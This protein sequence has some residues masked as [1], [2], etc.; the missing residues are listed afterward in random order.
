MKS[1][2]IL[3]AVFAITARAQVQVQVPRDCKPLGA[4]R[5][6]YL[7]TMTNGNTYQ[8][9]T[10]NSGA[11]MVLREMATNPPPILSSNGVT[12]IDAFRTQIVVFEKMP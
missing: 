2:M 3:F 5:E 11:Y 8:F 4:P 10:T 1:M 7:F 9:R 6:L 12:T